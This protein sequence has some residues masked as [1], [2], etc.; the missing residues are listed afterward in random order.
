MRVNNPDIVV[1]G[2][3][4]AGASIAAILARGGVEVLLLE[5][6]HAYRDRVRGEYIATWGVLEAR[7]LG[8]EN[9]IRSTQA[10]DGRYGVPFDELIDPSLA[11][12]SKHDN[13]TILPDVAGPLCASHPKS[14][15]ALADEAVHVGAEFVRGVAGVRVQTGKRPSI[16]FLNGTEREVRPRLIIGA[17]GRASTVRRQ[18]GIHLNKAQA[19]HV[20]AGLL[21][22]GARMA[23]RPV[24]HRR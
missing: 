16:T 5:R 15:Q 11:V 4:I 9:V 12:A 17:D 20:V 13:S 22:Q 8:L 10:V 19:T 14:C 6:Q 7:A 24:R 21:V 23:R 1:V 18:S 2:A 3:G